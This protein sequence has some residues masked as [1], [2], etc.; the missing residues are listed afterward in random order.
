[1]NFSLILLISRIPLQLAIASEDVWR[2]FLERGWR[3]GITVDGAGY[4]KHIVRDFLF[5]DPS[6]ISSL[7]AVIVDQEVL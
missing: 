5:F 2:L 7:H 4:L 3:Y 6:V 1:V